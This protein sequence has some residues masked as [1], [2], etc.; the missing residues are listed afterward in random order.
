M[1]S[2]MT[3]LSKI[4]NFRNFQKQQSV[5]RRALKSFL[6]RARR[7]HVYIEAQVNLTGTAY[8]E[9]D[10]EIRI[11]SGTVISCI[12]SYFEWK[13]QPKIEIKSGTRI[14]PNCEIATADRIEI[15]SNVFLGPNVYITTIAHGMNPELNVPYGLQKLETK[16][17]KIGNNCWIGTK[18]VILPGVSI[19]E[20]CI[21]GAGSIVTK[22]IPPFT[23]AV[24]N[25]AR[26]IKHYSIET[27]KWKK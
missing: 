1:R 20:G 22:S 26:P 5:Q 17:I 21:I 7:S 6:K 13:Y 23:M 12:D 24:G 10:P 2:K 18:T 11:C 19:G 3:F 27:K 25:P 16:P 9:F 8:L 4:R 15:G 14:G